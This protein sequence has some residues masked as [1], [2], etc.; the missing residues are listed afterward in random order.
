MKSPLRLQRPRGWIY[1]A[2]FILALAALI[3]CNRGDLTSGTE[4]QHAPVGPALP[5]PKP[6]CSPPAATGFR[7]RINEVMVLNESTLADEDGKFPPW[8]EIYNPTDAEYDLGGTPLSDDFAD[9]LKWKVPCIAEAILPPKGFLVIF[10]DGGT[11]PNA[12]HAN[13]TLSNDKDDAQL[14]LN[15]GAQIFR[16]DS[17]LSE[18]DVSVGRFP[19]GGVK[20]DFLSEPTPGAPNKEF[21]EEVPTEADFVRG[22]ANGDGRVT[23]SDIAVITKVATGELAAPICQDR[24]DANDDGA[25]TA[26]DALYV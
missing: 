18:P 5:P 8:I 20:L 26:E 7:M 19:D 16:F 17:T 11:D 24:L 23:V 10:L 25:V 9:P 13:F 4:I 21:R 6:P 12:L 14:L 22:D 2:L 3:S 1:F 15:R